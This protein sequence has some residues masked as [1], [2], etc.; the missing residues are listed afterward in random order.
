MEKYLI[1]LKDVWKIYTVGKI[2]VEALRGLNVNI[3][4]GEFVAVMGPSGSGK[5]TCV[6][7]IGCLDK[8]TKGHIYLDEK[9]INKLT[10]SQLSSI[11]G[12]KIG[13]VFQQFNIINSLT[14]LDNVMLPM[15]FYD[16]PLSER[17]KRAKTILGEM[18]LSHRLNH[19]PTEISGGEKQRVAI[20]R[21]L[22]NNPDII[23]ADEP[24]GNLDSKRGK[25]IM[26]ILENLH[27]NGKTIVLVTHDKILANYAERTI[28][29]QDG[30]NVE[31]L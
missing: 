20:A 17:R 29:I 28:Y 19:Y 22:A 27:K 9:D 4:K 3:G 14:I 12:K 25:E 15:M 26:E 1:Q 7:L 5:S 24:T 23:V 21:A 6:H 11:R 13:F 16:V 30:T 31:S 18:D 10:R 8:P 2:K